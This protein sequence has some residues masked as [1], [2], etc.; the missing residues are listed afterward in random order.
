MNSKFQ[1]PY[2]PPPSKW[3]DLKAEIKAA[4]PAL[5]IDDIGFYHR[6]AVFIFKKYSAGA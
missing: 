1:S 5:G 3:E 2:A 6:R 4:A